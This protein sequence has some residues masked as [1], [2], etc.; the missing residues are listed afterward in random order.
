MPVN[1]AGSSFGSHA[2]SQRPFLGPEQCP[3]HRLS[4][5][6][7]AAVQQVS[8]QVLC[9]GDGCVPQHLRDDVQLGSLSKHQRRPGVPQ[10]VWPADRIMVID[11]Y[12][13]EPEATEPES[14]SEV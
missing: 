11:D 7:P 14:P 10:F 6:A 5:G 9:D 8:V 1:H 12:A 2:G 4:R 3:A 13:V